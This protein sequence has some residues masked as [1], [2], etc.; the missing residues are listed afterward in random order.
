MPCPE[1]PLLFHLVEND[2]SPPRGDICSNKQVNPC[3]FLK[4]HPSEF[5]LIS[6]NIN[7]YVLK[8][9]VT[10]DAYNPSTRE[11]EAGASQV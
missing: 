8:L 6:Y 5:L 2:P 10:V 7:L 3:S 1:L 9:G 11:V 4:W